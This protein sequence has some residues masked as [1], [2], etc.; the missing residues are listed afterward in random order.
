MSPLW[1]VLPDRL[2]FVSQTN[3]QKKSVKQQLVS[4]GFNAFV[5]KETT[6]IIIFIYVSNARENIFT[7]EPYTEYR[8]HKQPRGD[9]NKNKVSSAQEFLTLHEKLKSRTHFSATT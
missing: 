8:K 2:P 3:T 9:K 4:V 1:R 6:W 5:V 7:G